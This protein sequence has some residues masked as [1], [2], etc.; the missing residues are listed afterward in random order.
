MRQPDEPE[1]ARRAGDGDRMLDVIEEPHAL[2]IE[3]V[4]A[5]AGSGRAKR[6]VRETSARTRSAIGDAQRRRIFHVGRDTVD[7][8]AVGAHDA[9]Q[10]DRHAV[11]PARRLR[12]GPSAQSPCVIVSAGIDASAPRSR[13]SRCAAA[14]SA[15]DRRAL[16]RL[17]FLVVREIRLRDVGRCAVALDAAVLQP[18]RVRAEL[19][20]VIHAVRAQQQRAAA[21]QIA[22]HPCDAALLERF[23]ADGQHF[24]GDEDVGRQ[25]GRDGEARA[26]RP[27]PTNTA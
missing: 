7:R 26:A 2:R 1:L 23:V 20:D 13:T 16:A 19:L 6:D 12:P 27:C 18:E 3:R 24:V 8:R 9:D 4:R 11:H 21:V 17:L 25:R 14:R 22:L 5:Q 15:R 10:D